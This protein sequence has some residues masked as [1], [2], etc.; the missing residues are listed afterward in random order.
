MLKKGF[1]LKLYSVNDY[2]ERINITNVNCGDTFMANNRQILPKYVSFVS[3]FF[4]VK[5]KRL[6]L[7]YWYWYSENFV[8]HIWRTEWKVSVFG[9]FLVH[10]SRISNEY[11]E[12]IRTLSTQWR[13]LIWNAKINPWLIHATGLFLSPLK[14]SE[15][16]CFSD[17][18]RGYRKRLV[19]WNGLKR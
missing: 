8:I 3:H 18:L 16:V 10:I 9:V 12:R 5:M 6:S 2:H 7:I 13:C 19:A 14:T 11:G 15:I 17:I 4:V 1:N